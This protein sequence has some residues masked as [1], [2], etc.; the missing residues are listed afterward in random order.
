MMRRV[1][2]LIAVAAAA[3]AVYQ[4][5]TRGRVATGS[6]ISDLEL[7][8][9]KTALDDDRAPGAFVYPDAS[10]GENA[11]IARAFDGAPPL[12]PHSLDGF[13]PITSSDNTCLM[14]H[15]IGSS[16]PGDPPQVP[17]SH[18]RDLRHA[19]DVVRETVAGARWNC[20]A[21]HVMQSSAPVLVESRFAS[22]GR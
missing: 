3:A 14:C 10:P 7:G 18:L 21:C 8:L 12:I 15:H 2:V 20:T 1:V 22:G 19:P 9:R 17:A 6:A 11:L 5:S 4:F 16:D 13:V